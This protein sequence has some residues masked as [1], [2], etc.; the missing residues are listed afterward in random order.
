MAD[1][2][3]KAASEGDVQA[4]KEIGDRMDGKSVQAIA[5]D[6]EQPL[7]HKIVREIVDSSTS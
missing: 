1:K 7:V 6:P 3:V 4:W 2:V 5:G